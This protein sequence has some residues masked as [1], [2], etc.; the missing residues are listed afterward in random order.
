MS[1]FK[2]L[3]KISIKNK[4]VFHSAMEYFFSKTD[5][6]SGYLAEQS[7][8]YDVYSKLKKKYSK[9]VGKTNFK[10]Y[11]GDESE[12]VWVCWFQ[13]IENAPEIVQNCVKSLKYHIKDREIVFLNKENIKDYVNLPDY[14]YEKWEKGIIS[15]AHFSDILRIELLIEHGGIWLDATTYLTAPLPDYITDSDFFVYHDGLFDKETV[16]MGSW[17]IRSKANNILLNETQNLLLKYWKN[18]DY[19]CHYFLF[20]MFFRTVTDIYEHEWQKMP[21]YNQMDNHI[22]AID[23][24]KKFDKK[25]FEQIKNITPVHKLTHKVDNSKVAENSYLSKLGELYKM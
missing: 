20:H 6:T 18:E 12:K 2:D 15:Y 24:C 10:Q 11:P 5:R 3:V 22:L 21:Y 8:K 25:R 1:N 4:T 7:V 17:L 19:L 13:G 9:Y 23:F 14:I 16:N